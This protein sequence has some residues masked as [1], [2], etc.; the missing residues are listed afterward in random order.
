MAQARPDI[1]PV[2]I[3]RHTARLRHNLPDA[4]TRFIGR[5]REVAALS[6]LLATHRLLTLTG[7]GG[8]GKT[9]LA[10]A[11]AAAQT[12]HAVAYPDGVWMVEFAALTD[13]TLVPQ[14]VA[15]VLS[16][17]EKARRPLLDTLADALSTR[18]PL[19]LLDNCEHIV[20]PVAAMV[21]ALLRACPRLHILATSREALRVPSEVT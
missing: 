18:A 10:L 8:C 7:S 1:R 20:A 13:P 19:L 2:P 4:L 16:V 12:A 21:D 11:V 17:R 14:A 5:E 15:A 9:R 6:A 3:D